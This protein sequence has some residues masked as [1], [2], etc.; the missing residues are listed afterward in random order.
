MEYARDPRKT[1][2]RRSQ[3]LQWPGGADE[4]LGSPRI[5]NG[6]IVGRSREGTLTVK[7]VAGFA[8]GGSGAVRG[9]ETRDLPRMAMLLVTGRR[10]RRKKV[11]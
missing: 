2:P 4:S 1:F 8:A 5:G 6:L 10:A 11:V 3:G 9:E 7:R